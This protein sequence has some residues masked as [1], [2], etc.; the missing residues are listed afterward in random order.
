[1]EVE[2]FG[3]SS[4]QEESHAKF[5]LAGQIFVNLFFEKE[6]ASFEVFRALMT[7]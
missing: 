3:A 7:S 4:H 5:S 2:F 6:E 1:V